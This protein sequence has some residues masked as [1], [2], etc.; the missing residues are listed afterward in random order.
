MARRSIA[1]LRRGF[2]AAQV[3]QRPWLSTWRDG[4]KYGLPQRDIL[5]SGQRPGEQKGDEVFDST[6]VQAVATF[7]NR[8]QDALFPT[9]QNWVNLEP[10]PSIK[11]ESVR[12]QA[13]EVLQDATKKFHALINR[14]NFATAINEMLLDF[15]LGTGNLLF[16]EGPDDDPFNF[17]A[18][19]LPTVALE[20]G[21]W[22]K[23]WGRY[24]KF[25]VA[26]EAIESMWDGVVLP[27]ALKKLKEEEPQTPVSILEATYWDPDAGVWYYDITTEGKD[28]GGATPSV[29]TSQGTPEEYLLKEPQIYDDPI[30]PWLTPR[31]A[32]ASN[33][34]YGR[35]PLLYALAD[36]RTVNAVVELVLMNGALNISGVYTGVDDGV[37][38]PDTAKII[39]GY[40]IP[41]ARNHGH[42]QGASLAPLE[43][44]GDPNMSQIMIEELRL[45][46]KAMLF[47]QGLPP[48]AGP[49][50]SATEIVERIKQ[51]QIDTGPA[52]GRLQNELIH[53]LVF[54]A[55]RI[56]ANKGLI[57]F[58]VM[59]DGKPVIDGTTVDITV[60]SPL[61]QQQNLAE[62]QNI[63]NGIQLVNSLLGPELTQLTANVEKIPR[64]IYEK[65]GWS[66]DLIRDKE[67]VSNLQ[68]N[69]AQIMAQN[70]QAGANPAQIPTPQPTNGAAA[71]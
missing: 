62:I 49:V 38:N 55:L 60:T 2:I 68:Q 36:I 21:D 11:D 19:A 23:I 42:P 52:F 10:G 32:L 66:E 64:A 35:G 22:G 61:A 70:L 39:P 18:A 65:L 51:L 20:G 1:K 28:G 15:A 34:I 50:R 3:R 25:S 26:V 44:A 31:F 67:Q 63:T 40:I 56:M 53:P 45:G 17:V 5:S 9:W 4:Y 46:I 71:P 8:M 37:L 16:L 57:T 24:R 13:R 6:A 33:E 29:A 7:A 43:R 48:E 27:D 47:N 14:S 30:G 41:V 54:R 59:I 69:V 58:P 12:E